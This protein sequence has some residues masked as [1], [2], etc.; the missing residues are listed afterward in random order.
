MSDSDT[1]SNEL[2][3]HIDGLDFA[4]VEAPDIVSGLDHDQFNWRVEDG[5]WSVAECIDHLYQTGF[6]LKGALIPT[7]EAA[8]AAGKR[9]EGPFTYGPLQR[10]FVNSAGVPKDPKKGRLKAPKL[11]V[12]GSEFDA[13]DL[14][15]KFVKLQEDLI[16]VTRSAQ[17]L[18]LKRIKV[19]SPAAR[20]VRL[21]IGM[22]LK[23]IPNHQKR[24]FLQ[25][26]RV[27]DTLQTTGHA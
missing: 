8:H 24:H 21:S 15:P 9:A 25:A 13:D 3:G 2:L 23:L 10:F 26:R 4:K 18:D 11:Y 7:I 16:D 5:S 27:R 17:G 12:P 22:W 6:H 14:I 1:I 19:S 20:I